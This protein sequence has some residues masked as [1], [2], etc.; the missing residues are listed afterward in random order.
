MKTL[1]SVLVLMFSD[2]V[3]GEVLAT[4]RENLDKVAIY[5]RFR[6]FY[7]LQG[8]DALPAERHV[9]LDNSGTPDYIERLAQRFIR[10][11]KFYR[12]E[13][14][15]ISP[16]DGDRYRGHAL[17]ID[18]NL[19]N[20]PAHKN[21][22]MNGIAY[23]GTPK[24]DR[25]A[26]GEDSVNV[27]LIDL[28]ASLSWENRSVE[29]ELFHLYQNGYTYFKNPWYTEGTARWSEFVMN[30]RLGPGSTLPRTSTQQREL[31]SKT[32]AAN[33]FWNELILR[34]DRA[35]VGKNFI[36]KLLETLGKLDRIAAK[37]RGINSTNWEESEQRS[38]KNDPYIWRAVLETIEGMEYPVSSDKEMNAL[39]DLSG[40]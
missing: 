37:D 32:Y 9:D 30:G 40:L 21:G 22:P 5:D 3:S 24:L 20:L 23:D 10:V 19:L 12:E 31:F 11:D 35:D 2:L 13:V 39:F 17:Y 16:L 7:A 34:C 38:K 4:R 15:L 1:F 25:A 36:R 26:A 8:V 33:T 27:L 18:V 28:S 14:G 29:H 6:F